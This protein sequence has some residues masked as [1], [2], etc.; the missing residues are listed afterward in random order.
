[1]SNAFWHAD[2]SRTRIKG[3][4]WK[5]KPKLTRAWK[6]AVDSGL[7]EALATRIIQ[8]RDVPITLLATLAGEDHRGPRRFENRGE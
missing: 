4:K 5:L 7:A 6:K 8:E 1:M 2:H 3:N